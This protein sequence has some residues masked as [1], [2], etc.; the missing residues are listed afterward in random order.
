MNKVLGFVA[1]FVC[2]TTALASGGTHVGNGGDVVACFSGNVDYAVKNGALTDYGRRTL[3]SATTLELYQAKAMGSR[4]VLLNAMVGKS[5]D[6]A[7]EMLV[8]KLEDVPFFA[9]AVKDASVKLGSLRDAASFEDGLFNVPDSGRAFGLSGNCAEV[10]AVVRQEDTFFKDANIWNKLQPVDRAI[11]QLHEEI[12]YIGA[13]V[14]ES[15]QTTSIDT[16]LLISSLL[17]KNSSENELATKISEY[18]F[19]SSVHTRT[20]QNERSE[21]LKKSADR[22][23]DYIND[24]VADCSRGDSPL[25]TRESADSLSNI[26][27]DIDPT[28]KWGKDF[29]LAA[30]GVY[31]SI[32]PAVLA[33]LYNCDVRA[34][35][36]QVI[37]DALNDA[38]SLLEK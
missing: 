28:G 8:T 22:V 31:D 34:Q 7:H 25:G 5:E 4:S 27:F 16:R 38:M 9:D 35:K 21:I 30:R 11:L 32:R 3:T 24:A 29:R 15:H 23:R 2:S 12:Y 20:E 18:G 14:S 6:V 33:S 1:T 19:F 17:T 37:L 10:Q 26:Y 36:A 13:E